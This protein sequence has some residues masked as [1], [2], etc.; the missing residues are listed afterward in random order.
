MDTTKCSVWKITG[1]V[2]SSTLDE[3]N[4]WIRRKSWDKEDRSMIS[5]LWFG[6]QRDV[7]GTKWKLLSA[8]LQFLASLFIKTGFCYCFCSFVFWDRVSLCSFVDQSGLETCTEIRLPSARIKDVHHHCPAV[9]FF[10]TNLCV[11]VLYLLV[12]LWIMC[13]NG[14]QRSQNR[15]CTTLWIWS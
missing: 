10:K 4:R 9:L 14:S 7:L 13:M 11:Q 5:E 3:T 1:T 15:V 12:C 6:R 2:T 8:W